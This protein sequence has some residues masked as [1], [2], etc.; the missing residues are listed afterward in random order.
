MLKGNEALA[1]TSGEHYEVGCLEC[2]VYQ[3]SGIA[4]DWAYGAA[5]IK[6]S[7][8]IELKDY[9]GNNIERIGEEI[10]AFHAAVARE[11]ISE[12]AL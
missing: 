11:L 1:A 6:Y 7:Y 2:I 10:Y 12:Y 5:G 3:C 4:V 9:A 8:T